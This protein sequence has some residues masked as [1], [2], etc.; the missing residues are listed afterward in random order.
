[1]IEI[2]EVVENPPVHLKIARGAST[3]PRY[4][5]ACGSMDSRSFMTS[6]R[7]LVTCEECLEYTD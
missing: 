1:M 2:T 5:S 4:V 6:N 3:P 7:S